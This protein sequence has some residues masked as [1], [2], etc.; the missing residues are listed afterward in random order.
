MSGLVIADKSTSAPTSALKRAAL[1]AITLSTAIALGVASTPSAGASTTDQIIDTQLFVYELNLARSDPAAFVARAG[2]TMSPLPEPRPPLAVSGPLLSSAR[3][4]AAEMAQY[5]YFAHQSPVTGIWPN[6]LARNHGYAL[7]SSWGD[8]VNNIESIYQGSSDPF[9]ALTALGT[10]SAHGGHVFGQ[11][12]FASHREIGAGRGIASNGQAYWAA[13]T[14]YRSSTDVFLTGVVYNDANNNGRMDRGEGLGGVTVTVGGT[15]TT[16]N[17]GG[18]YAIKVAPGSWTIAASG[19]GFSGTSSASVYVGDNNVGVDFV[20]GRSTPIVTSVGGWG[21]DFGTTPLCPTSQ[22]CDTVTLVDHGGRWYRWASARPGAAINA[23]YYGNP[24][25]RP[26]TGDW[27]GNGTATPGLYRQSDGYAYVRHTNTQGVADITFYFGNPSDVPLA[28]DF[29]GNGHDTLSLFRPSEGRVYVINRLGQDG[30][31][32]G[33]ADY[34][35]GYGG[36][37]DIPFTGD[38]NGNGT[39]TVGLYRPSNGWVYLRNTHTTGSADIAFPIGTGWTSV[40]AGDWNGDGTETVAAYRAS[41][42]TIFFAASNT[43]DTSGYRL[44]VGT[45]T[46]AVRSAQG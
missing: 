38:F 29:N 19:A 17:A 44:H 22:T 7:P 4:K 33:A 21:P 37:G 39:Q 42:G 25:D 5:Q 40:F 12:W 32:L 43:A 45:Y 46:H 30:G 31:G 10:S 16:T 26:F 15:S 41:T 2:I 1:A 34:S 13:H 36:S 27:N 14:A 9:A 24:G 18:G 11:G 23:F 28:G 6:K 8:N 35:Y 3:F 20:S